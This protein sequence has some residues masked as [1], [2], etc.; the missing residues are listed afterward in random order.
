MKIFAFTP[1]YAQDCSVSGWLHQSDRIRPAIVICPGGGYE[2]VSWREADPV[3]EKYF[4]AG[5]Q[6]FILNYSVG[7][8][9]VN[10]KPLLQLANTVAHIRANSAVWCV[11]PG[12]IA[13]CGFSAGGHLACSLGTLFNNSKFLSSI[14]RNAHI[15][16][17]AMVLAYPVI[18]ADEYAHRGSIE[19]V[20][21]AKEGSEEYCWFDLTRYVD[22]DTP[23]AFLW[24][25]AE[26]SCVPVENSM[27][28]A[29]ALS[30]AG[31]P[32]EYHIFPKGEHGMSVCTKEVD[33]LDAY[34]ARWMAWSIQW[35]NDLF[36]FEN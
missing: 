10:F 3:A 28:L 4:A 21:G 12:K 22:A 32:F 17:D 29:F 27:K 13:V 31:V 16:P 8:D 36:Q 11:D 30:S 7:A 5:Y 18:T 2:E 35:L 20:S 9:A 15:R 19:N 1:E 14:D 6:V 25:T 24:H 23:P 26:D 34:N 33:S